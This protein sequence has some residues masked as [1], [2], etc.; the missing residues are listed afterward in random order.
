MAS[1]IVEDP[2]SA[3]PAAHTRAERGS[4]A[5]VLAASRP[6]ASLPTGCSRANGGTWVG[7]EAAA[8]PTMGGHRRITRR[9]D[10]AY[11]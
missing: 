3:S 1:T 11:R 7:Q 8:G 5:T 2:V 6:R 10:T 4:P 9:G